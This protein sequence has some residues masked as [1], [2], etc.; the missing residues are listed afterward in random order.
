MH[1]K[2][3][4]R[5]DGSVPVRLRLLNLKYLEET[6]SRLTY[7]TDVRSSSAIA[8]VGARTLSCHL[9]KESPRT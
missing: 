1:W 7:E 9:L 2:G 8:I 3:R 4:T 6:D 5:D